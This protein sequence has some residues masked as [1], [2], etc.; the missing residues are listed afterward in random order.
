M[1]LSTNL[2]YHTSYKISNKY[3]THAVK[4]AT[5]YKN[6]NDRL[7][8]LLNGQGRLIICIRSPCTLKGDSCGFK[9]RK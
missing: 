7:H 2:K 5:S 8:V 9:E 6:K 3:H 1:H 4:M